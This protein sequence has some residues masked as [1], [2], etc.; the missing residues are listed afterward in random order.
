M[1][2]KKKQSICDD[3]VYNVYPDN[4]QVFER[5]K[6]IKDQYRLY[7]NFVVILC[8]ENIFS[9]ALKMSRM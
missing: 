1:L 9:V 8:V 2:Y 4:L 5:Y 6:K 3:R 7:C